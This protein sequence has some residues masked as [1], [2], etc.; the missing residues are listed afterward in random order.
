VLPDQIHRRVHQ[1]FFGIALSRHDRNVPIVDDLVKYK[2]WPKCGAP[3]LTPEL[4]PARSRQY[5]GHTY[6]Q[7]AANT[8]Q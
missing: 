7:N 4:P 2:F 6:T 8:V 1:A 5:S 3:P